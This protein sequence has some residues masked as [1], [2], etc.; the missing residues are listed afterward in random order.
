MPQE[1]LADRA[2]LSRRMSTDVPLGDLVAEEEQWDE[3]R[4][5]Q[6]YLRIGRLGRRCVDTFAIDEATGGLVGYTQ[7]QV[8]TRSP[9]VAYQQETLVLREHRGH[10]LGLRLKAANTLALMQQSPATREVRT[11]NAEENAPM[12][13]VNDALGYERDGLLR[14]WQK[15]VPVVSSIHIAPGTRLPTK[16]V[17]SVE[18]E[19]GRGLVGD[20]Y[21]G[22]KHRHVTVQSLTDL[23]AAATDLG[24][25]VPPGSTRRN[26]TIS[27]GRVPTAP[28]ARIRIGAVDLE[29]VRVAAPCRLLDD[30]VGPGAR[31]ALHQR[32][33]SVFRLVGSG[34]IR[35]G[36]AV[37][38][39]PHLDPSGD[40]PGH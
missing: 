36:D 34:T 9:E 24:A 29:V 12:L 6:E 19:E 3:E 27:T 8:T 21:H 14:E 30:Y 20:R 13:A 35:V 31:E 7:V 18:A 16:A 4:V 25:P 23:A 17:A 1:W 10:G 5:R 33:G 40:E 38:L 37:D 39:S 28:G 26:I 22:S 2:E 15:V 32:A 11:W